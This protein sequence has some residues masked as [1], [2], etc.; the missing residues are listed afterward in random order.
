MSNV[1]HDR[2]G[3]WLDPGADNELILVAAPEVFQ[4][5][6]QPDVADEMGRILAPTDPADAA[7]QAAPAV[8]ERMG[9]GLGHQ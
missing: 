2:S 8:S 9:F 4:A 3:G 6:V 1:R 7:L 5:V